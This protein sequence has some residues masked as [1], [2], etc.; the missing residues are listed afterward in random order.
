MA[1]LKHRYIVLRRPNYSW[2]IFRVD[3]IRTARQSGKG[4]IVEYFNTQ[5]WRYKEHEV[6][7]SI[8]QI[9]WEGE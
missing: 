5:A 2:G 4:S 7:E 6:Q 8:A 3:R 9:D 1:K